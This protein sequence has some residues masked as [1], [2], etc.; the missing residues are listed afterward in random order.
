M[1]KR[2]PSDRMYRFL[3]RLF[4]FDFQ[5]E[6]G[7]EM[8]NV[9]RQERRSAKQRGLLR[10]I[11]LWGDTLAGFLRIAPFEHLDVLRRDIFYGIRSL[12]KSPGFVLIGVTAL[13]IGLGAN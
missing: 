11:R 8:E 3:L 13:A 9:F 2:S 4:P 7:G 5:R 6:F 10:L 12:R 1:K